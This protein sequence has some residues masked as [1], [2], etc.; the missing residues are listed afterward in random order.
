MSVITSRLYKY[1]PFN[2]NTL[3]L[4]TRSNAYYANP[5]SFNDPFDCAPTIDVDIDVTSL[6]QLCCQMIKQTSS[7]AAAKCKINEFRYLSEDREK[8]ETD[9][10]A[11]TALT[12]LL[13]RQIQDM[14]NAEMGGKGVLSLS[15]RWQSLL[16]WS[17]YADEHRG[18]CIEYDT[19]CFNH[20][21]I[22]AVNYR[23]FRGIKASILAR[24]KLD[25]CSVAY[26]TVHA[27]YFLTKSREWRYEAEW[28]DIHA[29]SG[30]T[31]SGLKVSAIYFGHRC[32][33]AVA[34]VNPS[35]PFHR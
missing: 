20:S 16:M 29:S 26:K 33:D 14:V 31:E 2:T 23:A 19:T 27:A 24:W 34:A 32:H 8:F 11:E 22:E 10:Q 12:G 30:V 35:G 25:G 4:L 28:R 5:R 21:G 18:I 6:E 3:Q 7:E 13:S 1:R 15:A 17:H 9:T